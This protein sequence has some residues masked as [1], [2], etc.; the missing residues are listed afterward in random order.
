ML[1]CTLLRCLTVMAAVNETFTATVKTVV[2]DGNGLV[3]HPS[4]QLF[5]VPGV[6]A[7]ERGIFR[8]TGFKKRHGYARLETL[9]EPSRHRITPPCPHHGFVA[10]DC[11]G[12]P[13]QFVDYKAQISAKQA[14]VERA[15][16]RLAP[17]S[18][19]PLWPAPDTLGYRNRAQLKTDGKSIGY[20]SA[21]SNALAPIEDCLVLSDHNR[22]TLQAL[23]ATLPNPAW[24]PARKQAWTTLD[25][26]EDVDASGVSVNRRRPF[27]QANTVQNMRMRAWLGERLA[28]L[29]SD[30][31]VLELFAGAGNFTEAIVAAG[32]GPVLAVEGDRAALA[33]LADAR[34]LN[35][36]TLAADLFSDEG[37]EGVH[38]RARGATV[39]VLDPPREGFKG[40]GNLLSKKSQFGDIFYISCDL[41]TFARDAAVCLD[42]GFVLKE[43]QPLDQFPQTPHIELLAWFSRK[44]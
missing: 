32:S 3:E 35:V 43:V 23:L 42:R 11:G 33:A 15:L 19:R 1:P 24:R 41:A 5:F 6:W 31:V 40:I 21:G 37:I 36:E 20:V 44:R 4:G 27:R 14:F 16:A 34:L 12:C 29:T 18:V 38:R 7:E 17:K 2:N 10:G 22:H 39:L 25:L 8:I 13:W 9:L 26:D 30:G 28:S